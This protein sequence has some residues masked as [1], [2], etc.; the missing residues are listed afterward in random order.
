MPLASKV[1]KIVAME[2][3]VAPEANPA[4]LTMPLLLIAGLPATTPAVIVTESVAMATA[5]PPPLAV[6]V[7]TCGDAASDATFTMTVI[8]G[9]LLPPASESLR[10]HVF[11]AQVQPVPL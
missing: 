1:P 5:A 8:V 3:R 2:P 4:A 10:V 11:A 7:F 6:T 9:Y